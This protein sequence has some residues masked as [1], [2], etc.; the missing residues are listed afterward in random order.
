MTMK[1]DPQGNETK[2]IHDFVDFVGMQVLEVGCG[3]GRLMWRYA[4][5]AA[6]VVGIDP[7]EDEIAAAVEDTPEELKDRVQ[8]IVGGVED[9]QPPKGYP[10]FDVAILAWSL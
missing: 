5:L 4:E 9:Y 6:G 8:F 2:I 10:G 3:D 1:E 7:D